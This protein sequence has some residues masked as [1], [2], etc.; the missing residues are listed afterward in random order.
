MIFKEVGFR[1]LYHYVCAFELNDA[2]REVVKDWPEVEKASHMVTYGYI[3]PDEGLM[4]E[5][6][7]VGKQ[8]P[9]YFYFKEPY[10]G[11]R[12]TIHASEVE[13]VEFMF[14]PNLENRFYKK[15][16][17]RIEELKQYDASEQVE[18]SRK[19]AFLDSCRSNEYP[20]DVEVLLLKKELKKEKV[21]VHITGLG[22]HC[23][24]RNLE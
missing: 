22:D 14:F 9:K 13:D 12:I 11:K 21:W 5:I 15:Y 24:I 1:P 4:L 6:L 19:L 2:L 23:I 20:D 8:A 17:P 16:V 7:G 3:D 10:Q 18:E